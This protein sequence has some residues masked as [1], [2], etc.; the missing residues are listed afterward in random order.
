M[1]KYSSDAGKTST[2]H[3]ADCFHRSQI[4]LSIAW[5]ALLRADSKYLKRNLKQNRGDL[6]LKVYE[7]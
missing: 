4:L 6:R 7:V 2:G 1:E 3:N 5:H